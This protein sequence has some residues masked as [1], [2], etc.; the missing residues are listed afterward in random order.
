MAAQSREKCRRNPTRGVEGPAS[1]TKNKNN[2][3]AKTRIKTCPKMTPQ[4][5]LKYY[6]YSQLIY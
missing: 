6:S 4:L 5:N 3:L 1:A 2:I